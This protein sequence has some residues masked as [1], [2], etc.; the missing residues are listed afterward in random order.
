MNVGR[1]SS[2]VLWACMV[3]TLGVFAFF[4][5]GASTHKDELDAAIE[6]SFALSWMYGILALNTVVVCSFSF[7]R[8]FIRWKDNPKSIISP[9]IWMGVLTALFLGGYLLG[10]GTP[11]AI[12]GYEGGEN[13][14]TWLKLT[15][16]WIYVLYVL[17]GL[18]IIAL[19]TGIIGSYI[20]KTK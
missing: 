14:Y 18:T 16:M 5:W 4:Y 17:I 9:L 8:F 20:K 7:V 1:I 3:I 6:T 15:D 10:D 2:L 11:L 12:S 19:L 13:T